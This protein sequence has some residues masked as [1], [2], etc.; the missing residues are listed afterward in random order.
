MNGTAI[1]P[2]PR[3]DAGISLSLARPEDEEDV[4][5]LLV[6]SGLPHQDIGPHLGSFVVA[7]E[8]TRLVASVGLEV[9]GGDV[10]LL[11]SL[12]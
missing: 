10:G 6:A 2:V 4:R 1:G 8:G 7:R 5:A 11:R 12:G 9:V 3:P